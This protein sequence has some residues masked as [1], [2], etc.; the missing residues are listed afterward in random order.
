MAL[1]AVTMAATAGEVTITQDGSF[2]WTAGTDATYGQGF[3]AT[4][5]GF[6]LGLWK[7][8][9]TNAIVEPANE[10]RVY[11][12]A[13]FIIE[14]VDGAAITK[15]VMKTTAKDKTSNMTANGETDAAVG[16]ADA[17]TVTWTGSTNKLV[18]V[19]NNG[20]VRVKSIV[21]TYGEAEPVTKV[22]KPV[23]SL[24]SGTYYGPIELACTTA[25]EGAKNHVLKGRWRNL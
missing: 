1:F 10:I 24:P 6:N 23:L 21:I 14:N 16:N 9:S 8:N 19:A 13:A 25:T 5:E 18:L 12:N 3:S 20:Q 11:K 15:V 17:K 2:A 7:H 4:A 22:E